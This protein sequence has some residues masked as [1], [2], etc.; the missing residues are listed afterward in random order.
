MQQVSRRKRRWWAFRGQKAPPRAQGTRRGSPIS[1]QA[2]RSAAGAKAAPGAEGEWVPQPT[3]REDRKRC[4]TPRWPRPRARMAGSSQLPGAACSC[5]QSAS[6]LRKPGPCRHKKHARLV[7]RPCAPAH[8]RHAR[9][10]RPSVRGEYTYICS[11]SV[12]QSFM[13]QSANH[14]QAPPHPFFAHAPR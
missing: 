10:G 9:A 8:C 13:H 11:R 3:T 14:C 6:P 7:L 2:E 4:T 5:Q 1:P 12:N